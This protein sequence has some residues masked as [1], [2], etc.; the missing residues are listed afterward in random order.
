VV[1]GGC[2][3][4]KLPLELEAGNQLVGEGLFGVAGHARLTAGSSGGGREIT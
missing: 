2:P 4:S 1:A 3:T